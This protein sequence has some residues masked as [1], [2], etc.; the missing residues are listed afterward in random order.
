VTTLV[1]SDHGMQRL[2][3][4]VY[5]NRWLVEHGYGAPATFPEVAVLNSLS[6]SS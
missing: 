3:G 1:V 5:L 4:R 2:D 6:A